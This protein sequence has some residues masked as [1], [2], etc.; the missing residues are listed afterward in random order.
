MNVEQK[1]ALDKFLLDEG[2]P[3]II[4]H[5]EHM[6]AATARALTVVCPAGLYSLGQDGKLVFDAAGC[7]ECGACRVTCAHLPGALEW[8]HPRP[9]FGVLFRYG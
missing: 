7:L 6:D 1:L 9:T 4:P 8:R 3:H 2:N 5:Q